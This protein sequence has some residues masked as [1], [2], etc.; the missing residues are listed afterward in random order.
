MQTGV[1]ASQLID[2]ILAAERDDAISILGT[3]QIATSEAAM[4]TASARAQ[5]LAGAL[6][7]S[8]WEVLQALR[9]RKDVKG[10]DS[11]VDAIT[12]ALGDDEHVTALA[13][14]LKEQHHRA[15]QLLTATPLPVPPPTSTPDMPASGGRAISKRGLRIADARN[16]FRDVEKAL[17]EDSK[18]RVDVECRIYK[19]DDAN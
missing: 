17:E 8:E 7:S 11:V 18:L 12:Q 16:T 1:A 4:A 3:A 19:P 10:T 2:A 15:L 9:Q 5:A 6:T 14:Q 13:N